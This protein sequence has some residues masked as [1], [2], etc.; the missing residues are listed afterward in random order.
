M[1]HV[2][3][4]PHEMKQFAAAL[5]RFSDQIE[6]EVRRIDARSRA[7][8]ESWND[9]EYRKFMREWESTLV[10]L[11]RF[12]KEAPRYEQHV[13]RKAADLEAYLNSGR[14]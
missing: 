2:H 13:L 6:A 14:G 5:H 3:G 4:D 1:A 9:G 8:G 10:S 7:V 11:K 12:L